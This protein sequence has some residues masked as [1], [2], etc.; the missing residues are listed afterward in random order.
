M[1]WINLEIDQP[2]DGQ[3]C[4]VVFEVR[5]SEDDAQR[6]IQI[7]FF[8]EGEFDSIINWEDQINSVGLPANSVVSRLKAICWFPTD[9]STKPLTFDE[10]WKEEKEEG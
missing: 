6:F 10:F 1:N 9:L 2:E 3:K 7:D 5:H 8:N 4:L